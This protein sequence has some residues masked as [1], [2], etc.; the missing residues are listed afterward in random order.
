[1]IF[2]EQAKTQFV[3]RIQGGN[4]AEQIAPATNT[5]NL[6]PLKRAGALVSLHIKMHPQ[7]KT[8]TDEV[9][10]H[11]DDGRRRTTKDDD[12]RR[13]TN[14]YKMN[15]YIYIYIHSY[16]SYIYISFDFIYIYIYIYSFLLYMY[17]SFDFIYI[18]IYICVQKK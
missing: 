2:G 10:T 7:A 4:G 18:Y 15:I 3:L 13:T 16:L 9:A 11:G 12:G 8:T 6:E 17:I 5:N 14:T 1:M